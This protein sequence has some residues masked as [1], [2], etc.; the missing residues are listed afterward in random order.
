MAERYGG[1]YSPEGKADRGGPAEAENAPR[2][3]SPL[4]GKTPA[5]AGARLNLLFIAPLPLMVLAF[6]RAPSDMIL[7]LAGFA[8]LMAAAWLTR[9]GV[10]AH[11]AFDARKIA[12]RPAIPRKIFGSVLTGAG[13]AMAGLVDGTIGLATAYG[14]LGAGLH[15]FSF[16]LDPMRSKGGEGVDA[17][18]TDRVARAV[19]DAEALLS[20]MADAIL[21]TRD[22]RLKSRV[23]RFQITARD[24]FRAVENDPRDLVAARKY[25]SVY[26]RGAR[27]A[28]VKFSD[29]YAQSRDSNTRA[30]YEALLDDLE[31]NFTAKTNALLTDNRTDLDVEIEVL[32]DR[33][34]REGVRMD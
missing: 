29:L 18:Q 7:S 14:I 11:E 6:F 3:R 9:D 20:G 5:R 23:E 17:F 21:R 1:A 13:L 27:D 34:A 8:T 31:R 32:R 33:L 24:M 10:R 15:M 25:L 30:D 28:T 4:E 19:N 16:G 26:L 2:K 22:A 12:R